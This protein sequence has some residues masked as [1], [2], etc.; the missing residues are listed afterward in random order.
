LRAQA[1][2]GRTVLIAA[3]H[4]RVIAAA[5]RVIRVDADA[6]RAERSGLCEEVLA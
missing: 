3:H 6:E 4:P 2:A 1:V 5:D